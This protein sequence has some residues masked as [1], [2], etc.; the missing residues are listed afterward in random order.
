MTRLERDLRMRESKRR[1]ARG[2]MSLIAHPVTRLLCWGTVVPQPVGFNDKP[3]FG[4]IE[5]DLEAPDVLAGQRLREADRPG[6][7]QEAPFELGVRERE[8]TTVQQSPQDRRA[9]PRPECGDSRAHN[10]VMD[11]IALV[12]LVHRRLQSIARKF[13]REV[14]QRAQRRR[15]RDPVPEGHVLRPQGGAAMDDDAG[16]ATITSGGN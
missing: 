5:I 10:V 6:K 2:G 9:T 3:K 14:D 15:D 11:E 16:A 8:R 4:P 13:R 7:R 12:G 1:Q